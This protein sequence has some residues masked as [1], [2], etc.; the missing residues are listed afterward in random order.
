MKNL[1]SEG[2]AVRSTSAI[3]DI[4]A[5]SRGRS[6]GQ[7]IWVQRRILIDLLR[8]FSLNQI[9]RQLCYIIQFMRIP[10]GTTQIDTDVHIYGQK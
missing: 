2:R 6:D 9:Y 5:I 1:V 10:G 3:T 4:S 7:A 8:E